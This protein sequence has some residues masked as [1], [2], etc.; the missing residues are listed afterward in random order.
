MDLTARSFVFAAL[1]VTLSASPAV[2]Q[3]GEVL[4]G[5]PY[6]AAA[7]AIYSGDY[8]EAE[9]ALRRETQR[10]LRAGQTRWVDAI[11]YHAMLGEAYYQQGRNGPALAS[12]DQACQ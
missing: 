11:C 4:P 6:Y 9:R 8:L 1:L 10:G 2:G 5:G 7:E 3:L 12:F